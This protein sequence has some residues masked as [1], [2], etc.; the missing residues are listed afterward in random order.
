M[1]WHGDLAKPLL[2]VNAVFLS[3]A[4]YAAQAQ[5]VKNVPQLD[6]T[7][8]CRAMIAQP[9]IEHGRSPHDDV[10]HCIETE[11][12]AREQLEQGWSRFTA[13]ARTTCLGISSVG[14]VKPVYSELIGC[15]ERMDGS[16]R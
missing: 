11:M 4:L 9:D 1:S 10:K 6:I 12:Q 3:V 14:S 16:K 13:I 5:T 8:A 2:A 15:L 7:A